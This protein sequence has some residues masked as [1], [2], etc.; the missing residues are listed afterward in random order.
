MMAIKISRAVP[1][2]LKPEKLTTL[3]SNQKIK[4]S[5]LKKMVDIDNR[6]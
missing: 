3:I 5:S 4:G 2:T 1:K 6:R